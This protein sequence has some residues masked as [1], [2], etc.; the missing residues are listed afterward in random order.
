MTPLRIGPAPRIDLTPTE[1]SAPPAA[2]PAPEVAFGD[3]LDGM[4]DKANAA[5][6]SAMAKADALAQG[7]LDDLHGTMI[8]AKEAEI[9]LKLV[10][11]IRNK[12]L[13][14]FHELWRTSV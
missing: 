11:T 1:M 12:L 10:G 14:A 5:G 3:V 9:S 6:Q 4:V 13:D 7:T 2:S 8:A